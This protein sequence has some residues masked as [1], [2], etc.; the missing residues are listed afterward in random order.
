MADVKTID[1]MADVVNFNMELWIGL[2]IYETVKLNKEIFWF[3][4]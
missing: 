4:D 3:W 1:L 2:L